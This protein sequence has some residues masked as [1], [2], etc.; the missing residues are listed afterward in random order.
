M[1]PVIFLDSGGVINDNQARA[2][3][4]RRHVA[5]YFAP[6]LG[7][8]G[9]AWEEANR[10]T[11]ERIIEPA[12][13]EARMQESSDW[14]SFDRQ[15]N[16][17]WLRSMCGLMGVP[18]PGEDEALRLA[19]DAG[20]T[21]IRL[22]RAPMPGAAGA[23][24][25]LHRLG[26][27][28]H[29]ASGEYSEDLDSILTDLGVR[30]CFGRLYGPDLI[31]TLKAGPEYY[32]LVFKGAGVRPAETLVVDDSARALRWAEQVGAPTV[33]V[34]REPP[35]GWATAHIGS[36]AELPRLLEGRT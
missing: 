15:Y 20:R 6:R 34:Q 19:G 3:Q 8:D 4:W 35:P 17:D 9:P 10:I 7:G 5:E 25:A 32:R 13:W 28:L 14:L 12:A 29:T 16:L 1:R 24:L 31:N 30:Q 18:C 11:L 21:I 26:F 33:L 22:V 36:L 27:E 23:I 2:P